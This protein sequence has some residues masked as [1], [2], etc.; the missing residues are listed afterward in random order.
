[1]PGAPGAGLSAT[2]SPCIRAVFHAGRLTPTCSGAARLQGPKIAML[3][4]FDFRGRKWLNLAP[5]SII[6][7]TGTC[8]TQHQPYG[9]G[10]GVHPQVVRQTQACTIPL[11]ASAAAASRLGIQEGAALYLAG[12]HFLLAAHQSQR[13]AGA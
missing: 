4:P 13:A 12:A 6:S 5:V 7:C 8:T 1:M 10:F 2:V 11:C 9:L 3:V